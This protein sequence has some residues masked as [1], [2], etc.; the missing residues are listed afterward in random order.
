M[1]HLKNF[2]LV[3]FEEPDEGLKALIVKNIEIVV[4]DSSLFSN[5]SISIDYAVECKKRKKCPILFVAKDPQKLIHEYR[6]KLYSYE[7][8][9]SYFNDPLDIAEFTKK[10]QQVGSSTG[11]RAKRFSLNIPIKLFRLNNNQ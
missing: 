1:I 8:F 10:L 9:D 11:R 3:R 5:D 6:E 4:I 2:I 7:E